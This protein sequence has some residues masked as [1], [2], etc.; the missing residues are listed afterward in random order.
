MSDRSGMS[1][2]SLSRILPQVIEAIL[3]VLSRRYISYPFTADEQA[4]V[5]AEFVRS[6]N[7]PGVIGDRGYPLKTW[8][9]TPFADPRTA[10]ELRYNLAHGRTRSVV[11][12]TIG[13]LK[14]RW[15]CLD[16]SGGKLLYK[17]EKVT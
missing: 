1:Q 16:A 15:R 7:F 17:P 8:L 11:E 6:F 9:L 12:R 5:K 3:H 2:P 10:E 13:L 4:R 14:G